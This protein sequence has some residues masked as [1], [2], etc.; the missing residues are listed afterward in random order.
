[1]TLIPKTTEIAIISARI[2]RGGVGDWSRVSIGYSSCF[3]SDSDTWVTTTNNCELPVTDRTTHIL[4]EGYG[5]R[6]RIFVH[7]YR[8]DLSL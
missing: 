3:V 7:G 4:M 5:A 1:M 8:D 6:G 2:D